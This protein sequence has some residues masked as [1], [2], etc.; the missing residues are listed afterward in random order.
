MTDVPPDLLARLR[1]HGQD[2][3][4]AGWD[5]LAADDRAAFADQLSRIDFA[6]LEALYKR[7]DEPHAVLPPRDRLAPLPVEDGDRV[8]R[9]PRPPGSRP[10]ATARWPPWWWP[11]ARAAGSGSTSRR[12]MFPVGP[13]TDASLFQIHAEKVLALSRRAGKPVPFLVMTSPATHADT[14][15]F[16]REHKF[17]GLAADQVRF[18]QQGTMPALELATGR[19]LL[20]KPG[21]LFLSPNG[22]GGTLTA[23]SDSGLLADLKARGVKHVFYFQV[24]NPLVNIADPGFVGRTRRRTPKCRRRWCSRS[25]RGRRSGSWPWS[26]AGAGSWSTLTCRPRWRPSGGRAGTSCSGPATRP[27]TCSASTSWSGSRPG[28]AGW[29]STWPA[30]RSRTTTRRP[31]SR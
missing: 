12:G 25:S 21:S 18:F 1:R 9:R 22:H 11:A 5:R 13:V 8:R 31:A 4:L 26:T 2:H 20:E 24:D 17:F 7:R 19:L 30:R 10:S 16:F 29:L 14:E 15:A 3:V 23:L 27:S 6:E 28:P